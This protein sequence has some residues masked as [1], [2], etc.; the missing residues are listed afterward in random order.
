MRQLIWREQD[1]R[2]VKS[3]QELCRSDQFY[4]G[5]Q[6]VL[7]RGQVG[8]GHHRTPSG[9][10]DGTTNLAEEDQ[11]RGGLTN[12]LRQRILYD[13]CIQCHAKAHTKAENKHGKQ[14]I[15]VRRMD[16]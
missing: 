13:Q 14:Y 12:L 6:C 8:R 7:E 3:C 10:T 5:W 15:G 9:E 2:I 1:L 4:C 16:I 11:R